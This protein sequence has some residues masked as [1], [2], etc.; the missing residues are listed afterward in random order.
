MRYWFTADQHYGH[1]NIIQYCDRPFEG[2]REMDEEM[3]RRHNAVVNEGDCVVH[4]GDFY[5]GASE[6]VA[7]L[8]SR[9]KGR[10]IFLRGSH[11]RWMRRRFR[12]GHG[13]EGYKMPFDSWERK[14][15]GQWVVGCHYSMRSWPRSY[16]GSWLLH[17][18]SHGRLPAAKNQLDVGVDA[19]SFTPV[20]WE[21]IKTK[22]EEQ[23][24]V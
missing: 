10:H 13:I 12:S 14:I 1:A 19:W 11:D 2:V 8:I 23:N 22:M 9:L 4:L 18:H 21:E 3:I 15:D 7:T 17:G 16:H 20:S 6:W 24:E 5:L